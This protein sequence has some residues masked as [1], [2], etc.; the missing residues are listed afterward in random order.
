MLKQPVGQKL[1]TNI[2][3]VPYKHMKDGKEYKFEIAC[4]RNKVQDFLNG[5]ETDLSEV[6]Q[7]EGVF[8][9]VANGELAKLK[10]LKECFGSSNFQVCAREILQHGQQRLTDK[11][12]EHTLESMHADV[13]SQ[14]CASVMDASTG[15]PLTPNQINSA[16]DELMFRIKPCP[17][18][19]RPEEHTKLLSREAVKL[20]EEK[21][22]HR[23]ARV[24]LKLRV[25]GLTKEKLASLGN[26]RI[27]VFEEGTD[28]TVLITH[29]SV[30]KELKDLL[31]EGAIDLIDSKVFTPIKTVQRPTTPPPAI[32]APV[33]HV[34]GG[35]ECH[36]CN[37]LKF[38]STVEMRSHF[39]SGW[40]AFNQK[41]AVKKLAPLS[42]L[43]FET[44]PEALKAS[45]QAVDD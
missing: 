17:A 12:R 43:E 11:E 15:M 31:G 4:Y 32:P 1:H 2:A 9:S 44:L 37:G 13:V 23:V 39:R 28:S 22:P 6:L 34:S 26:D 3:V 14:V 21:L 7:A 27:L 42:R 36:V 10:D 18:K 41:R 20:L 29:P 33:V 30:F 16:L 8:T 35:P 19:K 25:R 45:F 40:H 24:N 38:P 5:S